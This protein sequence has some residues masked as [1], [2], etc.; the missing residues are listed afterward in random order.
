MK[1]KEKK[2]LWRVLF[3]FCFQHLHFLSD[4]SPFVQEGLQCERDQS[5]H[6][7]RAFWKN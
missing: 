3:P 4:I 2:N 6:G 1:E 7:V 5:D